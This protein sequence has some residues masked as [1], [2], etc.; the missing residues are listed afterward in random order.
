MLKRRRV[1]L[2]EDDEYDEVEKEG[3]MRGRAIF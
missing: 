3:W 1:V 2:R